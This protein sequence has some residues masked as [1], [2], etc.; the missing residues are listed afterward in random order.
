MALHHGST[1]RYEANAREGGAEYRSRFGRLETR[2]L[3]PRAQYRN[4][5]AAEMS[6]TV[7]I[8]CRLFAL[9]SEDE[10]PYSGKILTQ[11]GVL[12]VITPDQNACLAKV[13]VLT[14]RNHGLAGL[15]VYRQ[16]ASV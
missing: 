16:R 9:T 2:P 11:V 7:T 3:W 14:R 8:S 13:C 5:R 10:A 12:K 4:A 6:H 15:K 1:T